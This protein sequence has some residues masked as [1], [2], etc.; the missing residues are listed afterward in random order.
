MPYSTDID[1]L[2]PIHYWQLYANAN[3]T[4]TGTTLNGTAS[5][6]AFTAP[7]L[8]IDAAN[9]CDFDR[10][11]D[12]IAI[13]SSTDLD[14]MTTSN[15][16]IS[17]M[18]AP[19]LDTL[20]FTLVKIGSDTAGI[21]CFLAGGMVPAFTCVSGGSTV[22][23]FST[24]ALRINTA[25]NIVFQFAAGTMRIYVDGLL[26]AEESTG[27]PTTIAAST[28]GT[29]IGGAGATSGTI[30][31]PGG[32]FTVYTLSAYLSDLAIWNTALSATVIY[33]TLF[34]QSASVRATDVTFFN[35]PPL[36]ETRMFDLDN[37]LA[38]LGTGDEV[39]QTTEDVTIT[40]NVQ[41]VVN[42]RICLVNAT[43][44]E[45][46]QADVEIPRLGATFDASLLL[47]PDRNYFEH[48]WQQQFPPETL[49]APT[50]SG[51]GEVGQTLTV[52]PGT[53]FGTTP[54]TETYQWRRDGVDISGATGSTYV[55]VVADQ[56][57]TTTCFVTATN[58]VGN[59]TN[60]TNGIGTFDVATIGHWN[61]PTGWS[62]GTAPTVVNWGT[63]VRNEN[64]A[65]TNTSGTISVPAGRFLVMYQLAWIGSGVNGRGNIVVG[66]RRNGVD[67][68]GS[69]GSGYQ[70]D[71]ANDA[72][73]AMGAAIVDC[74][75]E[76]LQVVG[77]RD[78][79]TSVGTLDATR[80]W[81]KIVQINDGTDVGYYQM[82]DNAS[83]SGTTFATATIASTVTESGPT[84]ARTGNNISLAA[85][86][87]YLVVG[88]IFFDSTTA[89]TSRFTCFNLDGSFV[90]GSQG[91]AMMRQASDEYGAPNSA[92]VIE[93]GGTAQTLTML[94]RQPRSIAGNTTVNGGGLS[95]GTR[96]G[97]MVCELSGS[98]QYFASSD[99]TAAQGLTVTSVTAN[100]GRTV[101]NANTAI[102]ASNTNTEFTTAASDKDLL[103]LCGVSAA[104]T[105]SNGTRHTR[106][107][108]VHVNGVRQVDAATGNYNRGDQ[109]TQ[110][111][112]DS[113]YSL[114]SIVS[115]TASQVI[116]IDIDKDPD[117]GWND[118]G[119]GIQ[120]DPAEP[121]GL[122]LLDCNTLS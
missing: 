31:I 1:A 88:G 37:S 60:L 61:A 48:G 20:P 18:I 95:V 72:A 115:T 25:Y 12:N 106:E 71:T 112:Y 76:T 70:R 15:K 2:N 86:T 78:T 5:G 85:N 65:Y 23:L 105:S 22:T 91:Y 114:R 68:P 119:G 104:R 3:D 50:I 113:T 110:D 100:I 24:Q 53:Y 55:L 46:F 90:N 93:T 38:E 36:T 4:G 40:F 81:L 109:S 57:T 92:C 89:R 47:L 120:T 62:W 59:T 67:V 34:T 77:F 7:R 44:F 118:G 63:E 56:D 33:D 117:G 69:F 14:N 39:T 9:S 11:T 122:Y 82:T 79:D 52:T 13:A 43:Q 30:A 97:I 29:D 21:H 73:W 121:A 26:T 74:D 54:I 96:S 49:T 16:T 108:A 99:A 87:T 27:V 84:I 45:I 80:S 19:T 103:V 66:L 35:V 98:A 41:T 64:S 116:R 111:V 42:A 101:D 10:G 32:T 58:A 102:V 94:S 17:M 51:V 83:F 6:V 28:A 8:H 107:M 75:G